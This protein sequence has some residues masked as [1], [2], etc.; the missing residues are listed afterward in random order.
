MLKE[1][2]MID[3]DPKNKVVMYAEWSPVFGKSELVILN[4]ESPSLMSMNESEIETVARYLSLGIRITNK[5]SDQFNV[6]NLSAAQDDD[7]CNQ[8]R[9]CSRAPLA[10]GLKAWEGYLELMGE[11]VPCVDPRKLVEFSKSEVREQ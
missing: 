2:L 8:S 3:F 1:G 10:N 6:I 11:T 9:I 5:I 4:F 7:F